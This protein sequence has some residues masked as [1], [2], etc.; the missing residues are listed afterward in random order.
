MPKD[1]KLSQI[2]SSQ[3]P[4]PFR[5]LH[6]P[7]VKKTV[8]LSLPVISGNRL[9][10]KQKCQKTILCCF[11]VWSS[12][13]TFYH[14]RFCIV[15]LENVMFTWQV[16]S[17]LSFLCHFFL[18]VITVESINN[19]NCNNENTVVT[20]HFS[21]PVFLSFLIFKNKPLGLTRVSG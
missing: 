4:P 16:W 18:E 21:M 12:Q 8:K 13:P 15:Q 17:Q 6:S 20:R 2:G 3:L 5:R 19:D 10:N 7:G 14:N 1:L 11:H 9:Y